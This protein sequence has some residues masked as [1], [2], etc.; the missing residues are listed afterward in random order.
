MLLLLLGV[1]GVV[2]KK[3][4]I[5]KIIIINKFV[6]VKKKTPLPQKNLTLSLNIVFCLFVCLW[7]KQGKI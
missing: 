4:I 2:L 1:L 6:K 5:D 3:I 7:R